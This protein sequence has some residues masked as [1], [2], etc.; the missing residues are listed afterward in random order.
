MRGFKLAGVCIYFA[1]LLSAG[2]RNREQKVL[3]AGSDNTNLQPLIIE[4]L[5]P[6]KCKCAQQK[7]DI[8]ILL[9]SRAHSP[10]SRSTHQY[11]GIAFLSN[12]ECCSEWV[13]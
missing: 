11:I 2:W 13:G 12:M 1:Q 8:A 5:L 7:A 9:I 10:A 3:F 6:L 4:C